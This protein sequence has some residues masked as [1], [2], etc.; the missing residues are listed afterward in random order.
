MNA[1]KINRQ[2]D[3]LEGAPEW[4]KLWVK[5]IKFTWNPNTR[6]K[7]LGLISDGSKRAWHYF[8]LYVHRIERDFKLATGTIDTNKFVDD[9]KYKVAREAYKMRAVFPYERYHTSDSNKYWIGMIEHAY[10]DSSDELVG[11]NINAEDDSG[12]FIYSPKFWY[13]EFLSVVGSDYNYK[14]D[15]P[16]LFLDDKNEKSKTRITLLAE[17]GKKFYFAVLNKDFKTAEIVFKKISETYR[18]YET[19]NVWLNRTARYGLVL[20]YAI[21]MDKRNIPFPTPSNIKR[22]P[23]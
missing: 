17:Y 8:R 23:I 12:Y 13:Y 20:K 7:E 22:S 6:G 21:E 4:V 11:I 1:N 10:K 5:D 9:F 15:E 16:F 19:D 3:E 2:I 18:K 14:T